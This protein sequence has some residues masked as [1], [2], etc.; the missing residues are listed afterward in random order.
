VDDLRIGID[1]GGTKIEIAV[2]A[3]DGR[4]QQRKR[5]P[6]PAAY[7]DAIAAIRG[8]VEE[9]ET[10]RAG[11]ASVGLGIPGRIDPVTGVVHNANCLNGHALERDLGKALG[12]PVRV[13]NDAICFA[14]SEAARD[15]PRPGRLVFGAILGTGC[16]GGLVLDDVPLVG[17]NGMAGEWG[18]TPFPW[19]QGERIPA[20]R[21]WC[22]QLDCVET[23]VSGGALA[24]DCDGPGA[25]DAASVAERAASG[26]VN[27]QA[28]LDRH[29]H[30]LARALSWVVDLLDPDAIVLGGGL[31]KM[32]HLYKRLPTLLPGLVFN[33]VSTPVL[34]PVYGDSSGVRGA[35][36]LWPPMAVP[37]RKSR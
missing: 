5:V 15:E 22:G 8:L 24:I 6:T 30:R 9:V 14:L 1:F 21:C 36:W 19:A 29:T 37:R 17:R 18:H 16:G 12:R 31:S 33:G 2:V 20:R 4:I 10:G 3:R 32:Q 34:P 26:D 25:R 35:A 23:V 13:A 7:E 11:S 28:A 27:A